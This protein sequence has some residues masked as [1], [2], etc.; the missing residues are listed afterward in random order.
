MILAKV[1][2]THYPYS[3]N[4]NQNVR[5]DSRAYKK[6]KGTSSD[7]KNTRIIVAT[8]LNTMNRNM[9]TKCAHKQIK[10]KRHQHK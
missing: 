7:G 6:I 2:M 8:K 10:I 4:K 5:V 3:M 1:T 9:V